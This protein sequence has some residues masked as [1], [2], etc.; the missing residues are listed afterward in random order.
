MQS[1][2]D[3]LDSDYVFKNRETIERVFTDRDKTE[4]WLA[5]AFSY[6]SDDCADVCNKRQTPHCFADDMY[7]GDATNSYNG[8]TYTYAD[9]K[10]GRY[11]E[12]GMV[13]NSQEILKNAYHGIRQA[14]IFLQNIDGNQ[15]IEETEIQP[16]RE[17]VLCLKEGNFEQYIHRVHFANRIYVTEGARAGDCTITALNQ[18]E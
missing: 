7:F 6:L 4:Q 16:A 2:S 8:K 1:C 3:Y 14:S 10:Y 5:T 15:A 12:E 13:N 9:W 11:N 17:E 18:S